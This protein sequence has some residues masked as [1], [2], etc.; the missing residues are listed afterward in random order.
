[1]S[2]VPSCTCRYFTGRRGTI[3]P[4]IAVGG[5][6]DRVPTGRPRESRLWPASVRHHGWMPDPVTAVVKTILVWGE[7]DV[8]T[9]GSIDE[10][11]PPNP[12][13]FGARVQ[14]F[15]GE[16]SD[17]LS[18]SF[19]IVV[20]SPSWMAEQVASGQ[21]ERFSGESPS[22]MPDE[23]VAG[24]GIWFMRRWDKTKFEAAVRTVCET[25]SPGPDWGSVASRIGRVLPWEFSYRYDEHVDQRYGDS[26]PPHP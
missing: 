16:V 6:P 7:D 10:F 14:V 1:M 11:R 4:I 17:S 24:S 9:A 21:W 19:D 25:C 12:E 23:V 20:C 22:A 8:P 5:D 18:D 26:F 13:H 3:S 15:I 2:G